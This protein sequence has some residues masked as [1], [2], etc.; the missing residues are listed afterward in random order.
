MTSSTG[1]RGRI[2]QLWEA[3]TARVSAEEEALARRLLPPAEHALFARMPLRDRRHCLDVYHTLAGAGVD[4]PLVLRGA[5]FHDTGKVDPRGRP[6]PLA[7]YVAC[8]LLKR[9][10]PRAYALLAASPRGFRRPIHYYAH[11]AALGAELALA[12]GAPPELAEML[13][14]YHDD[15]PAGRAAMLQWAD[16][17]H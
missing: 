2:R 10:A 1:A 13:R 15:Q 9:L 8:V 11:H 7:W 12:A 6:V 4:D 16:L 14:H 3:L 5:L 17:Q